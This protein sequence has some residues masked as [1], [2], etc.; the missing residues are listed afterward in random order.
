MKKQINR[1]E[2]I[3]ISLGTAVTYS[4]MPPFAP[5]VGQRQARR[6]NILIIMADDLG[7]SD[8]GCY[9]S[10]IETPHLD[11]LAKEGMRFTQFYNCARCCPTRA[12][13]L[14][15]VYPHK[16]GMGGMVSRKHKKRPP[17]YQG[18]LNDRCI[19]IAEALAEAGYHRL[20]SGKWHLG[21]FRPHWPLDRGFEKYY[22]LISGASSY[23]DTSFVEPGTDKVRTMA[24]DN[25]PIVERGDDFYM[26]DAITD[27]AVTMIE[28]YSQENSPFFLYVAYTAPH[29]PLHALPEDIRKYKGK[30][31]DGWDVIRLRRYNR[32]IERGL[33]DPKWRLSKRDERVPKWKYADHKEWED[34]RMAVYA[35]QIDR[36]DQGI[37]RI[38][39]TLK[40]VGVEQ[41]TVVMFLSDN[42]ACAEI[43][44]GNDPAVMP[45]SKETYMSYGIGWAN[46][47]NTPLRGYKKSV[48]EGGIATSLIVR[49]P[50]VIKP[51]TITHQVGH[52]ID[53]MP[54]CLEIA[55]IRYP[56]TFRG[57]ELIPLD[58]KSLLPIFQGKTRDGHET[59]YWEHL[60]NCAIRQ[61]SWKLVKRRGSKEWELYDLRDD[62]T[63][64]NNL[65][66]DYP[67]RVRDMEGQWLA[68]AKKVGVKL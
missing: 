24:R 40:K 42:G 31:L 26:T 63:E 28:R 52:V 3:K 8:L 68:W 14:T 67:Q 18:F 34:M 23:F 10:S 29:W 46:V 47:S 45:G 58:G 17:A 38:L 13:L 49:W 1:R 66:A 27:N 43:L 19:T 21:E 54:T 20:M 33:I 12:S 41:N 39:D 6:P 57:K 4:F 37:G 44:R 56:E 59:L 11:R 60:G 55:G 16:A 2:F 15:G 48:Y 65:A 5:I 53:L 32:M 35:A 7:F 25:S 51:G 22:G 36:M 30:F 50:G 62:R 9:G 64:T 61:G